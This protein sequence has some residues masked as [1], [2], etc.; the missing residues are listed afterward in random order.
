M[1]RGNPGGGGGRHRRDWIAEC[2]Q[3]LK[4][5]RALDVL[6]TIIS[7]DILE[8][9]GTTKKGKPIYGQTRN[10]DRLRAI[11]F[12][13]HYA[14]GKPAQPGAGQDDEPAGAEITVQY[15][16]ARCSHCGHTY[17]ETSADSDPTA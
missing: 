5:A 8:Q 7:G 10:A 12:L 9:L 16:A 14:F 6:K 3:A 1:R 17:R 15:V 13:A 11:E 4:S 2:H